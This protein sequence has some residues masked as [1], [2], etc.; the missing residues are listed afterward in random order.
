MKTLPID[1]SKMTAF[2]GGAIQ[3]ATK[4]DGTQR[5]DRE[6]RPLFNVP[7]VL[8]IEGANAEA[9]SVR[10][11]GP[12]VQA[13]P[14]TPVQVEQLEARPWSF[15]GRSGVSFSATAVKPVQ[16]QRS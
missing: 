15:D 14:M 5:H 1:T 9:L 7:V 6:G 11:P 2:I 8:I 3:P 12:I 4:E 13:A 10:I 16:P